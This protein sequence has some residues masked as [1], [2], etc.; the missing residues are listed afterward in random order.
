MAHEMGERS[1]SPVFL[2]HGSLLSTWTRETITRLEEVWH[3][4]FPSR[5]MHVGFFKTAWRSSLTSP[6]VSCSEVHRLAVLSHATGVLRT[7]SQVPMKRDADTEYCEGNDGSH[8]LT[9]LRYT[10]GVRSCFTSTITKRRTASYT[11][12]SNGHI[13]SLLVCF[14]QYRTRSY[15]M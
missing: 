14:S 7:L 13:R 8:L 15:A 4:H 1:S 3:A 11:T 12:I 9:S 6:C 5:I 2:N 10:S